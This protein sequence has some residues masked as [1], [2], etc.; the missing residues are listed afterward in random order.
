VRQPRGRGKPI[1]LWDAAVEE[2]SGKVREE[3]AYPHCG[4]HW[5]KIQL[6]RVTTAPVLTAYKYAGLKIKKTKRGSIAQGGRTSG[7]CRITTCAGHARLDRYKHS[8][9][10]V[11]GRTDDAGQGAVGLG[12]RAGG[13]PRSQAAVQEPAPPPGG[14]PGRGLLRG[15]VRL[16]GL[17]RA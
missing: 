1:V 12:G 8:L 2:S 3:F 5:K 6:K 11:S 7:D 17:R 4:H 16:R 15:T 9:T 14:C 10:P 13:R